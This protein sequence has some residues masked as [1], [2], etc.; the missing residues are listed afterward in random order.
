MAATRPARHTAAMTRL[1]Q[2]EVDFW[3]EVKASLEVIFGVPNP[4]IEAHADRLAQANLELQQL[5][6][7]QDIDAEGWQIEDRPPN[8]AG[9]GAWTVRSPEGRTYAFT[10]DGAIQDLG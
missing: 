3:R 8:A 7:G 10:E 2:A 9:Q 4:V 5:A 1:D 6:R